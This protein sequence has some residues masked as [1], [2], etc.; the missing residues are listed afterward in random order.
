[1]PA[2]LRHPVHIA[3]PVRLLGD[4][5]LP[6]AMERLSGDTELTEEDVQ[7]APELLGLLRFDRSGWRVQPLCIR[8]KKSFLMNGEG[9]AVAWRKLKN[10]PFEVL[11]ERAGRLLRRKS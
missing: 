10:R 7:Q 5:G 2:L 8:V 3:E 1:V 6:L 9:L 4:H 11:N